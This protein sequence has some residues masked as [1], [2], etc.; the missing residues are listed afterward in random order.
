MIFRKTGRKKPRSASGLSRESG[1]SENEVPPIFG[2]RAEILFFVLA[3]LLI[4]AAIT[5]PPTFTFK[6]IAYDDPAEEVRA[7][8][9]FQSEDL[10]A[11]KQARD[12]VAAKTSDIYKVD[13]ERVR[14]ALS[15]LDERIQKIAAEQESFAKNAVTALKNSN[16]TQV[17][18]DVIWNVAL[19][20]AQTLK[21]Q[22]KLDPATDS[23]ALAFWVMP[24]MASVPKRTFAPTK[25]NT[26]AAVTGLKDPE[27]VAFAPAYTDT[28]AKLARE[29]LEY[30]LAYGVVEPSTVTGE[31]KQSIVIMR[32]HLAVGLKASDTLTV[33]DLP[34]QKNALDL[35]DERISEAART[36]AAASALT[37]ASTENVLDW[38]RMQQAASEIAKP[39]IRET[40]YFDKVY[41]EGE[42]ER[43]WASVEPVMKSVERGLSI[44]RG[45][46]KWTEQSRSDVRTY[47][48][49]FQEANTPVAPVLA[50]V[51]AHS[52]F[53]MLAL[54]CLVRAARLNSVRREEVVRNI[55]LALLLLVGILIVGRIVS[56]FDETGFVTPVT[57]VAVLLA[58]L[59]DTRFAMM[60]GFLVS[61]LISIQ[62]HYDWRLLVLGAA[63]TLASTFGLVKVRRR[64]VMTNAALKATIV[65]MILIVAMTLAMDSLNSA[66]AL[67]RILLVLINGVA[68]VTIVPGL[69]PPLER[70]FGITTD[71]Q[72]LEYSDLNNEVLS[73][74]A[75]E[76]PATYAHSLMLGQIAEA[77]ADAIGANGLL[78]RVC[79]YY[80]DIGKLRRPEYFSENQNGYNIHDD[81]SPRTS[82]RAI[83][84]H[85]TYGL[86]MAREYHLPKPIMAG[87]SEHHGT[88]LIS[89]FFQQAIEHHMRDDVR[90]EDF[91]YPGPKPQSR[92]TAILM[93]CDAAESGVRSIKN[94]NEDR[95][96]DFVEKI[97]MGRS[98]DHQFDECGLTLKDLNRIKEVV[99]KRIA[100]ALHTRIA[101]PESKPESKIEN[102]VAIPR[103][104]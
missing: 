7:E 36:L 66:P 69:L 13:S 23:N 8:I 86:E 94:P 95:V 25:P 34:T 47:Y 60:V 90:E 41:T 76:I 43:A 98:S 30:T 91:R 96:R 51:V 102:V 99:A 101:Y 85:V 55:N 100:S 93:I 56:Y 3:F 4:V 10:Q 74:L 24:K 1:R 15:L 83:A 38:A 59:V 33:K 27:G 58:I 64:S 70:L 26:P 16:S 35:L 29:A 32:D 6:T 87:I 104:G 42:R 39:F 75:I 54:M 12:A 79:A 103:G 11:T 71:I 78:A 21:E 88:S 82:A 48:K 19:Q 65:G 52:I 53:V 63:M 14:E 50:V 45:G 49:V 92:E 37:E 62:F 2:H 5:E 57:T 84:A 46:D 20:H 77:A 67:R 40:L 81:L 97:V 68:C 80:H 18:Y 28:L 44:K 9:P 72:L 22:L 61:S 31:A 17:D 89:F 73:K